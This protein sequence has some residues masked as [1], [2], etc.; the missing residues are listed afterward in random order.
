M[1]K[2]RTK[3]LVFGGLVMS[4]IALGGCYKASDISTQIQSDELSGSVIKYEK[5]E[6]ANGLTIVLHEDQSDPLVEVNI[7]YHV[8]SAREELGRSGFAHF[9]EHMM[10]Q[11]SENVADDEHFKIVT[12]AGGTMNGSTNTDFT[13][14]YQTV[15]INQLE[16][17]LWL[18]ADRM[19][20]LLDAVTQ[21]KFETQRETVK[22]ERGQRVDSQ[23]YGLISERTGEALYPV[24]HPYSWSTIGYV[25]DL[26][27]VNV[28]D[29]KTFFQKWYGPNNAV[30][31]IGG[32][33]DKTQTKAWIEK[34]FSTIPRGPEV[35]KADKAPAILT[36]TRFITLEDKVHLPLL[37]ITIPTVYAQHSDE[38]ALDVLANILGAG[39]TSLLY[40]NMVQNGLA[41]QAFAGHP[42]RE[43]ACE[44]QLLAL[45]NP[46]KVQGLHQMQTI[47]D[48]TLAEFEQ[49]GVQ[50]DDL[51]RTK[52]SIESSTIFG[53][54]SVAG[55]VSRLAYGQTFNNEPDGIQAD[56]ERYNAVTKADV[57]RVYKKYVKS[58]PAVVLSVVPEGQTQLAAGEPNFA[59]P[60]RQFATET[61]KADDIKQ[62]KIKDN[63][64]RSLQPTAGVNPI[65][66][67]PDYWEHSL[68]NGIKILGVD[69]DE[70]PTVFLNIAIEG[71]SL[72]NAL[73]KPGV[74]AMTAQMMNESTLLF[75]N[76]EIAN[77]LALLGSNVS[78]AASGRY[79]NV[80]VSSL[81]KNLPETLVILQ[82]MLFSP[83]FNEDD[84]ARL[85]QNTLQGL[86]Q[87]LKSPSVL[88]SRARDMVLFGD[89]T[90]LGMP[91][92]GTT[93]SVQSIS[94]DDLKAFYENYYSPQFADMVIV[95]DISKKQALT[96]VSMFSGWEGKDYVLPTFDGFANSAKGKVYLVDN[97]GGVQSVVSIVK[98]ALVFDA[99]GEYF[100]SGLMNFPLGGMFNSRI[101]LNL[102]E[103]KG[104]TY[105][106][107]SGFS[108]GKQT[109]I[110]SAGA[111]VAV[112][113]T[114]ASIQEF[115]KEIDSFHASGMTQDELELMKKAY[116]QRDALSS[117]TPTRK[118]GI[119]IAM[120]GYDLDKNYRER[121]K[122]IINN[123]TTKQLNEIAGKWLD[124]DSM[125]IIVVGDA[126]TLREKLKVLGRE[127]V[128]LDVPK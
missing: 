5:Y 34:Y 51:Q 114:V 75:S 58:K 115:L 80:Y 57:M 61:A 39:K 8:G 18:E 29:L 97:P 48:E 88:A 16:K 105:G 53:L 109:G 116:T 113:H 93:E 12:E 91:E 86:Q 118:A 24:G 36:A 122:R 43:L 117:E 64:D 23:P 37:Q 84:F 26:D 119:L 6:L 27:R 73:A 3:K 104:Y 59:L 128:D 90:I 103:D 127:I 76:V 55:K 78:F 98:H 62:T 30:L 22:N 77:R 21:E 25:E 4:A 99:E 50:D 107:Q 49:R 74:A 28:N 123:A 101:N 44:F 102:R 112:Q 41:L 69:T 17:V 11:G 126:A 14:Y 87:A 54:Q 7:T 38:A 83:G 81:S 32:A 31:T 65:G 10:F 35:T 33:I 106:A 47:I 89:K 66:G 67:I 15:P 68:S 45:V 71:G 1:I 85:K 111:D 20:F 110:F 9:F 96:A 70:T 125:D 124:T 46:E 52:A 13:N 100:K 42:C 60:T 2:N 120:L 56:I 40:K 121:Q 108:G 92:G 72:L 19:G 82:E 79:T 95:G 63:F 94:L